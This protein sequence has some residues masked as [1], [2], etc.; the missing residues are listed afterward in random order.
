[1]TE[2][3]SNSHVNRIPGVSLDEA[4]FVHTI[5]GSYH[6]VTGEGLPIDAPAELMQQILIALIDD[7][8]DS[9]IAKEF[10]FHEF[11][12]RKFGGNGERLV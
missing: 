11:I 10:D 3:Q 1:M 7:G 8:L 9:G 4:G 6:P 2:G 5:Y 12:K